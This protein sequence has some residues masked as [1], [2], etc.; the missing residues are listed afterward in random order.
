MQ[1]YGNS[2][3]YS[4]RRVVFSRDEWFSK[5]SSPLDEWIFWRRPVIFTYVWV[6]SGTR[7]QN[8]IAFWLHLMKKDRVKAVND[9]FWWKGSPPKPKNEANLLQKRSSHRQLVSGGYFPWLFL[10]W[11]QQK[12][13]KMN[14]LVCETHFG[15]V[16]STYL[17]CETDYCWVR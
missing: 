14:I 10:V 6:S 4:P 11:D 7:S 2:P 17:L 8:M 5:S 13:N 15:W 3:I 9:I 16:K 1:G 12:A